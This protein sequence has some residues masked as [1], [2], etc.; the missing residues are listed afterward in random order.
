MGSSR[1]PQTPRAWCQSSHTKRT[2]CCHQDTQQNLTD[3]HA[4]SL[5]P[6][7]ARTPKSSRDKGYLD[8]QPSPSF[9]E[10]NLEVCGTPISEV[11][12]RTT[13]VLVS[14][15]THCPVQVKAHQTLRLLIDSSFHDFELTIP[16][17]GEIPPSLVKDDDMEQVMYTSPTK[18]I[19]VRRH[20]SLQ[21]EVIC[22]VSLT[23]EGDMMV[24]ALATQ[25]GPDI[26]G[27]SQPEELY[28]CFEAEI[29]QQLEKADALT[30][31]EQKEMLRKLF[32]DFQPIFSKDPADQYKLVGWV[33]S[34]TASLLEPMPLWILKL[35]IG[36]QHLPP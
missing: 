29:K 27:D 11:N 10:L 7:P 23:T 33:L 4:S 28:P 9:R 8:L 31:D 12:H 1:E 36:I 26:S 21:D 18:M 34:A 35:P 30:S 16:V 5:K 6:T 25:P 13:Y 24:Y 3:A 17:I 22:G 32:L 14:N 2:S 20:E 15:P 19:A